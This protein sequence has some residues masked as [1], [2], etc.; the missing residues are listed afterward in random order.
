MGARHRRAR[1]LERH[2]LTVLLALRFLKVL[3]VAM[4][5]AGTLGAFVAKDLGDRRRFAYAIAG[6]GFGLT[7][8]VGFALAFLTQVSF[9]SVWILGSIALS[10]MAI[11]FV[12][13]SVGKEGRRKPIFAVLALAPLVAS[14]A[15]MIWRP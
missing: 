8:A 15:L 5:F 3:A 4:L 7:W 1:R 2:A 12:L 14:V 6:P 13:F 10:M 11:Q 9:L